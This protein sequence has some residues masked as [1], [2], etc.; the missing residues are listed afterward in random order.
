MDKLQKCTKRYLCFYSTCL[1][2]SP[3]DNNCPYV[4]AS[5][6]NIIDLFILL[7][8]EQINQKSGVQNPLKQTGRIPKSQKS[9]KYYCNYIM[10]NPTST[11]WTPVLNQTVQPN[12]TAIWGL[13]GA[14]ATSFYGF[15]LVGT[16]L[17]PLTQLTISSGWQNGPASSQGAVTIIVTNQG[18][19]PITY[20]V[21]GLEVS[22]GQSALATAQVKAVEITK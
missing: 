2:A 7:I 19:V 12:S 5:Q 16:S 3:L 13:Y 9:R 14:S 21:I 10:S 8:N 6:L 15:S 20:N 1:K 18:S 11:L 17:T 4:A 22:S